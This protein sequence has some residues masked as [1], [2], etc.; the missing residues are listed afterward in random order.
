MVRHRSTLWVT[1]V[2][3]RGQKLVMWHLLNMSRPEKWTNSKITELECKISNL[4]VSQLSLW[5]STEEKQHRRKVDFG[6]HKSQSVPCLPVIKQSITAEE[7]DGGDVSTSW[8]PGCRG[9]ESPV[10]AG[11]RFLSKV[12]PQWTPSYSQ[13]PLSEVHPTPSPRG[14][15][16]PRSHISRLHFWT[17]LLGGPSSQC[18]SLYG[19]GSGVFYPNHNSS[20][21][22]WNP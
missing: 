7:N 1:I 11:K 20:S 9:R 3:G 12:H 10:W 4:C 21:L 17:W 13:T 19:T 8:Q 5:G 14:T 15:W 6:F 22:K 16:F 18:M 2:A